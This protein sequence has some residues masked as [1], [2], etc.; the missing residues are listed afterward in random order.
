MA[1]SVISNASVTPTTVTAAGGKITVTATITD[2]VGISSVY[3]HLLQNGNYYTNNFPLS[4]GGSGNVYTGS[5]TLPGN[6][7]PFPVYWTPEISAV[8]NSSKTTIY[9]LAVNQT[10]DPGTTIT[11]PSVTPVNISAAGGKITVTATITNPVGISSVYVHLLQNG[12]YYTNNFSL[13]NGGS[14]NVYTGSYTLP[15]N[16]TPFPVYWTPEITAISNSGIITPYDLLVHQTVDPGTVIT[17]ATVT[18]TTVTAAGGKITV[19]A[20]ITNPV[21]ISSVYVHLL[22]NGNY[23]TNNFPLSNSG[24]GNVYTGSYTL[25]GNATPF[26][27]LWTPE[28]SAVSASGVTTPYDLTVTETVDPGTIITNASVTPTTVTAAGGKIT[29]TATITDPVG[30][31]SVYVHLLQNGNYYT[32]NF[33]LSN[34]GSGNVYTGSYT[35]PSNATPF[36]VLWTPE[37]SAVSNSGVTTPYDLTVNQTAVQGTTISNASV[38]PTTITAAGGKIT[39]T[40]T[41]T[42]PV[43]LSNVYVH[44]LQNGNYYTNNFP[45]SNGGSGNIYTGSYTLPGNPTIAPVYWTPEIS[46]VSNSGSTTT[47]DLTVNQ[48]VDPGTV[49]TNATVTPTTITAAGG[50]ITVTA[51][52]TNPVGLSNVY[53]HLLQNGNYYTN[54]FPLSNGGSG[55]IYTG[56]YTLPGNATIVPVYW[57]PEITAV[58]NS[59]K[60]T[61]YDLVINQTTDP[62]TVITNASVTPVNISAAGGKITVTATITDPVGISSVY[63]HL[64]QNGN[65]YTNNF[66]LSN[67]GSGNVYTGSYTLP[68]NATPFSVL[69]TPEISAVS[70]SGVTTPYDL[71]VTEA[72]DPGTIITNASVTPTTVTA[73]GGKITVTATITNPVG[74][75]SV[76]VH[77]LQNGNYYTNSFSLSNGGSG[78]IYTGSYTLPGNPTTFPVYWT[79]EISAVSNSGVTTPYDLLVTESQLPVKPPIATNDKTNTVINTPVIINV[80]A[81]DSD[82][83]TPPIQV[84]VAS[85]TQATHGAVAANADGTLTYTPAAN[86]TGI[87]GF[88]YTITNG[89]L[90]ATAQVSVKVRALTTIAGTVILQDTPLQ[91][92]PVV[93]K[94]RST[95]DGI[96]STVTAM[97]DSA[98]RFTI[99]NVPAGTYNLAIKS[100]RWLQK[101]VSLDTTNGNVSGV[102]ASLPSGDCNNDNGVDASDF[103]IFVGAYNS[104]KSVLGSGY[105]VR[106]DFNDDGAVDAN[107]FGV[108]VSD[109]N[110]VGDN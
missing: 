109:Y 48:T 66:P 107:D 18:P 102:A 53:V 24:S 58:S 35:L 85:F 19:T 79:P 41:I 12:N 28:I 46:A 110:T 103:G 108:F 25:P 14:G 6:A 1:Q 11:N 10:V 9:D 69:W 4:N 80:I 83:N 42:D 75:S 2:P 74:I 31:S 91:A 84:V 59:G 52:I 87:D 64:L 98:G 54:N 86:F 56:S 57:T 29:V 13:S 90:T 92:Q 27:V 51:T 71:T 45:L 8:N 23:Y 17:N 39:V 70:A 63:V 34:G 21:G 68:G 100:Y 61:I 20:T 106:A 33:P 26:S 44:L 47:Y 76:Y 96:S 62:G 72:V 88:S 36:P 99:P 49:I 89:G 104:S 43:G 94:F 67:G 55:N 50:K 101:V 7:T 15:G 105:D 81:N 30:I 73:A 93:F 82:P 38:T 3:V 32:N 97:P 16:A 37:I 60:T 22:Q 77:L 95:D 78:S 65:Y 5:Y 40:A